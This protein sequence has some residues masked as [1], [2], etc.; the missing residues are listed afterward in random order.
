MSEQFVA[1]PERE[2]TDEFLPISGVRFTDLHPGDQ[3]Q[4]ASGFVGHGPQV[5]ELTVKDRVIDGVNARG[6]DVGDKKEDGLYVTGITKEGTAFPNEFRAR[7]DGVTVLSAE[8]V[9][10]DQH[11][12]VRYENFGP[13]L[14]ILKARDQKHSYNYGFWNMYDT[15]L[16][17]PVA[18]NVS[19]G[20]IEKLGLKSKSPQT[21]DHN[22][23]SSPQTT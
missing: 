10:S 16:K 9:E 21:R 8:P 19:G 4:V 3:I 6:L 14:H 1:V 20:N 2:V 11:G 23:P 12:N 15:G 22:N 5:V 17:Q 18:K 7:I 13:Q